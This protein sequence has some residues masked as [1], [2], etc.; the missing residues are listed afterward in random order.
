MLAYTAE[1]EPMSE[2]R[3]FAPYARSGEPCHFTF[4][5]QETVP[6]SWPK[7]TAAAAP[8]DCLSY[9]DDP[10]KEL[11][12]RLWL[13][14]YIG[15]GLL[16]APP[17]FFFDPAFA[18]YRREW[19]GGGTKASVIMLKTVNGNQVPDNG[20]HLWVYEDLTRQGLEVGRF[21]AASGNISIY[22]HKVNENHPEPF[23]F[24]F[25]PAD[26][27]IDPRPLPPH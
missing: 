8:N 14:G 1:E 17:M 2:R 3:A 21:Y 6:L 26:L 13:A 18:E 10:A 25:P 24:Y 12:A 16:L 23:D 20:F 11:P 15:D 4:F 19:D 7:R 5:F 22:R 27:N 9:C